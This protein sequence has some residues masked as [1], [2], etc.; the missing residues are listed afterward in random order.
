MKPTPQFQTR[1]NATNH[2]RPHFELC[3]HRILRVKGCIIDSP[4]CLTSCW[5]DTALLS[6]E[7]VVFLCRKL[8]DKH[9]Q[10]DNTP[11]PPNGFRM[12]AYLFV[13]M[14]RSSVMK[15]KISFE[16]TMDMYTNVE[17]KEYHAL[18]QTLSQPGSPR[19]LFCKGSE[20]VS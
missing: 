20:M 12:L 2:H 19:Q 18:N 4:A 17:V 7:G 6:H 9:F 8:F 1:F 15:T 5:D 13:F 11:L 3:D 16:S 10:G 14:S